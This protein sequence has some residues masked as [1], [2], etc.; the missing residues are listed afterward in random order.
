[1]KENFK[2]IEQQ[3][4]Y[5]K[6]NGFPQSVNKVKKC[7]R[8]FIATQKK[9]KQITIFLNEKKKLVL[10]E[11]NELLGE[12]KTAKKCDKS[13]FTKETTTTRPKQIKI[14]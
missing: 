6:C 12:K 2:E 9:I 3:S 7:A 14:S 5:V 4:K 8:N 13:S 10:N 1:M 11:F